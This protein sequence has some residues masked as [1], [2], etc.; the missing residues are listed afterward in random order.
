M[1]SH[2]TA[3]V[4]SAWAPYLPAAP[5]TGPMAGEGSVRLPWALTGS[6]ALG[7]AGKGTA[8]V[9]C[10]GRRL[11]VCCWSV[12]DSTALPPSGVG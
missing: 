4:V 8:S 7:E 9:D 10:Q 1:S 2:N 3:C 5:A 6:R 11:G 12:K